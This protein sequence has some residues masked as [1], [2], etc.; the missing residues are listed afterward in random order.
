MG[1]EQFRDS[2]CGLALTHQGQIEGLSKSQYQN[3]TEHVFVP[4]LVEAEVT[5]VGVLV[6]KTFVM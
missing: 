4:V 6:L 2:R 5:N 1:V 3:G